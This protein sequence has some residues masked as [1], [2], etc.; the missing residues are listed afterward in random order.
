MW[1]SADAWLSLALVIDCSTQQLLG[2]HL[3]RAG[4]ASTASAALGQELITRSGPLGGVPD[5]FLLRSDNGPALASCDYTRLAR[6]YGL[7]QVFITPDCPQKN[8]MVER[9]V[10]TLK[11][12]CVR[13]HVFESRIDAMLVIAEWIAFYNQQRPGQALKMMIR[14]AAFA[15]TLIA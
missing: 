10:R 9:V 11:G 12:R 2:R 6:S 1:G 4:K 14:D 7:K 8:D 3:S 5:P 13:R 15:A